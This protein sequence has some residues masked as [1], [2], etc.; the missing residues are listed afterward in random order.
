MHNYQSTVNA[1]PWGDGP[2]QW[3]AWSSMA[4]ALPYVEGSTLY[5]A[6]NFYWGYS[7]PALPYNTTI[8]QTRLSY[9]SCPSDSDRLINPE[10]HTNYSGNAGSAPGSLYDYD[11]LGAFNG[12]FAWTGN[13]TQ[14]YGT[15]KGVVNISFAD[16][17]DGTS[18]TAMFSEKV[19]GGRHQRRPHRRGRRR[20]LPQAFVE[21][22]EPGQAG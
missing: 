5:N 13:P 20:R 15:G 11:K 10:G 6:L 3:N 18:N 1:L 19:K 8:M 4:L 21:Y 2:D 16:I 22:R 9:L 12:I 17:L 7:N 14:T